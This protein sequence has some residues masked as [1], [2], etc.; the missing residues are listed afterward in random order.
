[1]KH[2]RP[3]MALLFCFI[4]PLSFGLT[5]R[6]GDAPTLSPVSETQPPEAA[7]EPSEDDPSEAPTEAPS[8]EAPTEPSTEYRPELDILGDVD[9]N[10]DVEISDA[11]CL[12]R[13]LI[14]EESYSAGAERRADADL[15]GYVTLIDVTY[16]QGFL[17]HRSGVYY[18]GMT[19]DEA[20]ALSVQNDRIAFIRN[21]IA[22][23]SRQKGVDISEFNGDV[24]MNKLKA[25]GYT[26]VI[27]RLGY[28]EDDPK[29]DDKY[30]ETNVKKAEAAGL[31]WGAYLYSYA[32]TTSHAKSELKHTLRLLQGK[33]PTMPIAFDWEDDSYKRSHGMP[34]NAT[35]CNIAETYL[36]GLR[37]AGYYPILYTAYYWLKGAFNTPRIIDTFDI[38]LAQWSSTYDYKDRPIGMWQYGGE[39]NFIETP[40]IT[41]L[42]G[43]FDKD[44]CYKNY[45]MII[46][47]Y[48]WNNHA[49]LLPQS[50]LA[51]SAAAPDDDE[52]EREDLPPWCN[53]VMGDS[54]RSGR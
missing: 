44:Y 32:L 20:A 51:S 23:Y 38:W 45:P 47:A 2:I 48:G 42:N 7:T 13:C 50:Y 34:S 54:L 27:I 25:Q 46:K 28:G 4:I 31:D 10:G 5:A 35:V 41:G 37:S 14:E 17:A 12:Q 29:Q 21:S 22:D 39:V 49:P 6:A 30:F 33:H 19:V 18:I 11:T 53:G 15:D 24:D 43:L 52:Y 3:I 36:S 8:Q 26:F 16:L 9:G 1:M 40:Y